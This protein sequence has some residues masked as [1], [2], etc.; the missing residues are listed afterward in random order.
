M[1][2]VLLRVTLLGLVA[3]ALVSFISGC[4]HKPAYHQQSTVTQTAKDTG[5]GSCSWEMLVTK[6]LIKIYLLL[7]EEGLDDTEKM[8]SRYIGRAYPHPSPLPT[9][10]K[11]LC[12]IQ[13]EHINGQP[14]YTLTPKTGK[15]S[16]HIIYT[17]GGAYINALRS[18][19][20]DMI[21]K[22]IEKTGA[23]VTVPIYPLAPEHTYKDAYAFLENVYRS[24]IVVTPADHIILCGDSAGGG[25]ALG[26][27][28]RYRDSGLPL[29]GRIIL[30][31]P[32]LDVTMS[33]PRVQQ[34]AKEDVMLATP[35]LVLAGRWW[36][37]GDD[38]HTTWVS[39]IFGN[40]ADLP[41][42]DIFQ[43]TADM[44][45]ADAQLLKDKV[46]AAGGV[47]RMFEYPGAFHG[48]MAATFIPESKDV[49]AR[50]AETISLCR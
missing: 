41:P 1:K 21:R 25:L 24:V 43:G 13:E 32:W 31:A 7:T 6:Q 19:H 17:H 18:E 47:V 34:L 46:T 45:L 42:I 23:T 9:V 15:R 11:Q 8:H 40:L 26:Q 48:F 2:V 44:L 35:G 37:D 27:A 30:F 4:S 38:P 5:N 28:M 10:L 16:A 22:L 36:A 3:A 29:P 49:F 14:V 12:D 39:P 20:W 50:I 33:N